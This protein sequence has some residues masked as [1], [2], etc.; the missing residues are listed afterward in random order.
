MVKKISISLEESI[1]NKVDDF[2]RELGLNRSA[3]IAVMIDSVTQQ[4]KAPDSIQQLLVA[5]EGMKDLE[6]S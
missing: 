5:M 2:A 1:L 3:A 4:R 6:N